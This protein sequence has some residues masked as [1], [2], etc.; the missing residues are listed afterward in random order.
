MLEI[1]QSKSKPSNLSELLTGTKS[2]G[3]T[4]PIGLVKR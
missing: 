4:L 3:Q 1:V 2:I